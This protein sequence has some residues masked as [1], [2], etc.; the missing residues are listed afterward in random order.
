MIIFGVG[1]ATVTIG[2]TAGT[3]L[4]TAAPTSVES[5]AQGSLE[6]DVD[7]ATIRFRLP[8]GLT[9]IVIVK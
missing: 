7:D 3:P 9:D 5:L 6:F 4:G 1:T 8:V 2:R